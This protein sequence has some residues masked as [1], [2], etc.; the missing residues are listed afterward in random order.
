MLLALSDN[1]IPN[2]TNKE[3][4]IIGII[5]KVSQSPKSGFLELSLTKVAR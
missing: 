5:K 2:P 1:K 4:K 3:A